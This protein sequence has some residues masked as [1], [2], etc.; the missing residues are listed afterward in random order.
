[1]ET[2]LEGIERNMPPKDEKKKQA[3]PRP[4]CVAPA[5]AQPPDEMSPEFYLNQIAVLEECV[6]RLD[7]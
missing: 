3:P 4:E 2:L 7:A 6:E 1:L 5:Q